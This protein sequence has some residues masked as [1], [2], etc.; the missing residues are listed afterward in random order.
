MFCDRATEPLGWSFRRLTD[1]PSEDI[2]NK[3]YQQNKSFIFFS[4]QSS[5]GLIYKGE[6]MQ[7]AL[8]RS[9]PVRAGIFFYIVCCFE[10]DSDCVCV[11]FCF[12]RV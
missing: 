5:V 2:P 6:K 10:W 12:C 3:R 9:V 1:R 8:L 4:R 7:R 11:V